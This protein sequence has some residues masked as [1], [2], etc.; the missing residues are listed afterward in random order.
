MFRN[1]NGK[2]VHVGMVIP[3]SAKREKEEK[4]EQMVGQDVV[5]GQICQR[6]HVAATNALLATAVAQS[7]MGN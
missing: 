4:P 3:T 5:W 7:E 2:E 6:W 1:I